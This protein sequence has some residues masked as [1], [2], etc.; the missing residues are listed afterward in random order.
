MK[1]LETYTDMFT[2]IRELNRNSCEKEKLEG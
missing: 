1:K 2:K